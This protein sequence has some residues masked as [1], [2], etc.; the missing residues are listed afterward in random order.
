MNIPEKFPN[1]IGRGKYT[2]VFAMIFEKINQLID[3]IRANQPKSSE[4]VHVNETA[5]GCVMDANIS[6][7]EIARATSG[8]AFYA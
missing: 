8:P 7:P 3:C 1:V 5:I 6:K 2:K 4:T